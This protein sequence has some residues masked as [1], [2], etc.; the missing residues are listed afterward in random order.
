[1]AGL[2]FDRDGNRM[3][4][5]H[6]V[7]GGK[8][9]RYYVSNN[10]IAGHDNG[11]SGNRDGTRIPAQEIEQHVAD[12]VLSLLSDGS[13]L[14][15]AVGVEDRDP[16]TIR[17][18]VEGARTLVTGLTQGSALERRGLIQNIAGRVVLED[19]LIRID[20]NR[21]GLRSVL[22]LP[23]A[24]KSDS[25]DEAPLVVSVPVALR[26]LG[27]EIRLVVT[28][29][30]QQ[31]KQDP[32]LIKAIV[33]AH[34]WLALLRNREVESIADIAR[35]ENLQRTYVSS[36][37]PLAFLARIL[38]KRSSMVVSLSNSAL[39][40]FWPHRRSRHPGRRSALFLAL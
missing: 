29:G 3:T 1:L 11:R 39:I 23:E 40:A 12:A 36:L 24:Q 22:A 19:D 37:M 17:Y 6:A 14:L 21:F 8:R 7:R 26:R 30:D 28:S 16:R 31:A 34:A 10:L 32:A 18:A 25:R 4:P 13:R 35:S 9:Y 15:A 27:K 2:L 20:I 33:R 5:T 38:P